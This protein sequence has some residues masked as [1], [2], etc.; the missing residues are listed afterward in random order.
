MF[1]NKM[2]QLFFTQ[3]DEVSEK[4]GMLHIRNGHAVAQLVE[5]LRYKL[6]GHAFDFR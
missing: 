3:S 2:T 5:E 1:E 6:E 4:F